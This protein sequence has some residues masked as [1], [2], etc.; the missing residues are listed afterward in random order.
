[1]K[2]RL[3]IVSNYDDNSC[4]IA[5]YARLRE[6]SYSGE[7][8]VTVF[9]IKSAILMRPAAQRARAEKHI[10]DIC[11]SLADFDFVTID[12]EF[13]IWGNDLKACKE[14]ISRC[15]AA[16]K[17]LI[18]IVHRVD[19]DVGKSG[20]FAVAQAE[21]FL[22]IAQ[23]D[24]AH[25]FKIVAH[26]ESEAELLRSVHGFTDVSSH[27]L[28]FVT[29]AEKARLAANSNPKAWKQ[30]Y[31]FDEQDVVVGVFG[32]MSKYKDN[33]NV[34]RALEHLPPQYKLLIVGGAHPFSLKPFQTDENVT[35]LLNT[36]SEIGARTPGF[37]SRIRFAGIL[38]DDAF[39][40]AMQNSDFVVVPYHDAGQTASGVGS[41]A[42]ELG[43]PIVATHTMLFLGYKRLYG[44]CFEMYDVGNYLDL[45][46]R[47]MFF[48]AGKSE[49]M[50]QAKN[51]YTPETMAA[52]I[53][54]LAVELGRSGFANHTDTA[55]LSDLVHHLGHA[56]AS[57]ASGSSEMSGDID[58]LRKAYAEAI[59]VQEALKAKLGGG[60]GLY[61]MRRVLS[62]A[63]RKGRALLGRIR[64][65]KRLKW[66]VVTVAKFNTVLDDAARK[67]YASAIQTLWALE[68]AAMARKIPE[69]NVQQGFMLAAVEQLAKRRKH[70]KM[71]CVGSYEDTASMSL[72]ALGYKVDEIDPALN[73]DL[74]TYCKQHPELRETY[75]IVFSTSVIEHVPDDETFAADMASM[76]T[77]GGF[78]VL[79]CDYDNGWTPDQAKPSTDVRLYTDA[80]MER[81]VK[82]MGDVK[83]VDEPD[84]NKRPLDFTIS[85]NGVEMLYGFA[86]LVAQRGTA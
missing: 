75:D 29:A 84:W 79:T 43:R 62:F 5:A 83:L 64:P 18:L 69:A 78:I 16:A 67:H 24:A 11:E 81:L 72:K 22:E 55:K 63:K 76:T 49:R 70:R 77:A 42:F 7:F 71:L 80:D 25:P 32:A 19:V 54:R 4:G 15:C 56:A 20:E 28:A 57:P 74:R 51:T 86:S 46:D 48:D 58:H 30:K 36:T 60:R 68:P 13:G 59:E 73:V 9:D 8:D 45:R 61:Q 50:S 2:P 66:P 6:Q 17:A 14:R 21:L 10:D 37:E 34:M 44:D 47:I 38:G 52:L 65:P 31:G 41:M 26:S 39:R 82:A 3:A 27:P 33:S 1:M 85:E 53:K 40:Q 12:L 23:R 35:D